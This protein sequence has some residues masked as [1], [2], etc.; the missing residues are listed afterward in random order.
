MAQSTVLANAKKEIESNQYSD[1]NVAFVANAFY[2]NASGTLASGYHIEFS[3]DDYQTA[4]N[5]AQVLA[6]FDMFPKLMVRNG[7]HM[8]YLKSGECICNLLG[9][10]GAHKALMELHNE[11][12][13]RDVRNNSNRRVNCDTGNITRHVEAVNRQIE[14]IQ[15]LLQNGELE[16]MPEKIYVTAMA[17]LENPDMTYDELATLLGITKSGLVNR[18]K[19]LG[20]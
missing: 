2:Y 5:L 18:L 11:I 15:K 7:R 6:G 4:D 13:L 14:N 3:F 12:A 20:G 1:E 16:K 9:V 8:V 19:V 10:V 17:R